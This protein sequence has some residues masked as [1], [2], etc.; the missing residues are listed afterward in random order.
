MP[1]RVQEIAWSVALAATVLIIV[2]IIALNWTRS[3][4]P[5]CD[6]VFDVSEHGV[7][8]ADDGCNPDP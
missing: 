2:G 1:E 8:V 3:D 7:T 4:A 5:R 6:P